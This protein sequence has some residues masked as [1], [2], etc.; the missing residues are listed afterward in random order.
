MNKKVVIIIP[1]EN[2]TRARFYASS[3]TIKYHQEAIK[4]YIY[5][6]EISL[7]TY[8]FYDL[9]NIYFELIEQGFCIINIDET[10]DLKNAIVY[11]PDTIS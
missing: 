3:G 10:K 7:T 5:Q 9:N 8:N 6:N 11:L 2:K 4:R 1:N